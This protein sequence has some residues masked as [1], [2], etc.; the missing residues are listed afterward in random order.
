MAWAALTMRK[1]DKG[2]ERLTMRKRGKGEERLTMRNRDKEE[3]RL[4]MRKRDKGEERLTMR[5]RDKGEERLGSASVGQQCIA[6]K[7]LAALHADRQTTFNNSMCSLL[8]K[9]SR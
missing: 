7:T 6:S 1:R 2:E 9:H 4:T 5:K 3:E 8:Q